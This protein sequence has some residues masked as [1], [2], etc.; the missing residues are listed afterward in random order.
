MV[1]NKE[2]TKASLHLKQEQVFTRAIDDYA[3]KNGEANTNNGKRDDGA[4]NGQV[5]ELDG[6]VWSSQD[7]GQVSGQNN[8]HENVERSLT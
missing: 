6:V 1:R 4:D 2:R 7:D 3:G 5:E 8:A